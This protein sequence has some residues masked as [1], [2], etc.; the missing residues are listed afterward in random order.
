MKNIG[1]RIRYGFTE[2]PK[3]ALLLLVGALIMF[4]MYMMIAISLMTPAQL[5]KC[6]WFPLSIPMPESL[7]APRAG[8]LAL[9][10]PVLEVQ[11]EGGPHIVVSVPADRRFYVHLPD[12][13]MD[14]SEWTVEPKRGAGGA[15]EAA[16]VAEYRA[17]NVWEVS[18]DGAGAYRVDNRPATVPQGFTPILP[19]LQLKAQAL[20]LLQAV[21]KASR[22]AAESLKIAGSAERIA[23]P[24]PQAERRR[25]AVLKWIEAGLY[26]EQSETALTEAARLAHQAEASHVTFAESLGEF[27]QKNERTRVNYDRAAEKIAGYVRDYEQAARARA[28]ETTRVAPRDSRIFKVDRGEPVA[29]L[30]ADRPA[31][32]SRRF[33][34][35]TV[36]TAWSYELNTKELFRIRPLVAKTGPQGRE[37]VPGE[38]LA[39]AYAT[40]DVEAAWDGTR[41]LV[42][43]DPL[44]SYLP[45]GFVVTLADGPRSEGGAMQTIKPGQIVARAEAPKVMAVGLGQDT[46]MVGPATRHGD[47]Y[48]IAGGD[49]RWLYSLRNESDVPFVVRVAPAVPQHPLGSGEGEAPL[50]ELDAKPG[51]LLAELCVTRRQRTVV[52]SHGGTWSNREDGVAM[53]VPPGF[54]SKLDPP[55]S[56]AAETKVLPASTILA[57]LRMPSATLTVDDHFLVVSMTGSNWGSGQWAYPLGELQ[58]LQLVKADLPLSGPGP[59]DVPAGALIAELRTSRRAVFRY[60]DQ[61]WTLAGSPVGTLVSADM[62]KRARDDFDAAAKRLN[63]AKQ[64][65]GP[66]AAEKVTQAERACEKAWADL[67]RAEKGHGL[68]VLSG[69]GQVLDPARPEIVVERGTPIARLYAETPEDWAAQAGR[70]TLPP[71]VT[72]VAVRGDTLEVRFAHA[73]PLPVNATV[74]VSPGDRVAGRQP[75]AT[76]FRPQRFDLKN[77]SE[78][79]TYVTPFLANTV[80]VAVADMALSLLFA[81]LAAFVFSRF[82]FPG[83]ALFYGMIMVLMMIPGVLNLIP[84]YVIVKN[85]GLVTPVRWIN[86]LAL[87]LPSIAGGLTVNIYIMRNNLEALAKDLFDAARIDGASNFQTYWHIALPLSKP[88]MGT[89]AIFVLLSQWNNFIW[90]W[91][92]IKEWKNMPVTAGLALLQGQ[93]LSD[94]GLQM[95]GSV[96]ASLPLVVLFFFMMNL[97]IRGIQSGAIK[98]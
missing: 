66:G 72:R 45:P 26:L 52:G 65:A 79:A 44:A 93:N 74:E 87:I 19:G 33:G 16:V 96:L 55:M 58:A 47:R 6:P 35:M 42:G 76:Y 68:A 14:T 92:V 38:P 85:M 4:P 24:G 34:L 11:P 63:A 50:L 31:R 57:E 1:K 49:G 15:A 43:E 8:E 94:Y 17:S 3:V 89:L 41:W 5:E 30:L 84:M 39:E 9:K 90:P 78:A 32:A 60:I 75:L 80:I 97:F 13:D 64:D 69:P 27:R 91:V 95:A 82:R 46:L 51:D 2:L 61:W 83:K 53:A 73:L 71:M 70:E 59:W 56:L 23:E 54:V 62:L 29:L 25:E 37:V 21:D 48:R 28:A 81:S 67:G 86:L 22:A 20:E 40:R 10:P 98:A 88:I 36:E 18:Q 7:K 77:Y 12:V